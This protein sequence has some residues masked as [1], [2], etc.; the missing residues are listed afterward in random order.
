MNIKLISYLKK[1]K[2]KLIKIDDFTFE[3][4]LAIVDNTLNNLVSNV[5]VHYK[6]HSL[7]N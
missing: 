7:I 6:V 5:L 1:I 2:D 4:K 3:E